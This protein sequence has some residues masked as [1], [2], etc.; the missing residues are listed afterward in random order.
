[1]SVS[2]TVVL[3]AS[4]PGGVLTSTSATTYE[5]TID[6]NPAVDIR[7]YIVITSTN[8]NELQQRH[9]DINAHT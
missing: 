9:V 7:G 8:V 3:S 4:L 1:M 2:T 5:M 6:L